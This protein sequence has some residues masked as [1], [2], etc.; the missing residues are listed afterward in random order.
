M[1]QQRNWFQQHWKWLVPTVFAVLM[2]F[3]FFSSGMNKVTSDLTL[4]YSDT[5][6]FN[7][8]LEKVKTNEA[9]VSIIGELEPIDKLAVLEG[10]VNYSENNT[11]VKSSIRIAG[12]KG[13]ARLDILANK[14][15]M[16][17][18]YKSIVVRIKQSKQ[19][20]QTIVILKN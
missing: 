5:E 14:V 15:N 1:I 4:A 20:Q 16:E 18:V 10:Q 11:V 13:K 9:A 17:W 12:S 6:L 7:N 3:V 19:L 8:A 2:L